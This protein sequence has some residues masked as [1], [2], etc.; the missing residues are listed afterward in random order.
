MSSLINRT[1]IGF[2]AG[3]LSVL[4]FH[5][6]MIGLLHATGLIGFAPF[7]LG[8][9]GPLRVPHLLDMC[10]WG[11]VWGIL[12]GILAPRLPGPAWLQGVLLGVAAVLAGHLLVTPLKGGSIYQGWGVHSLAI[13]LAI[14]CFWGIGVALLLPSLQPGR[15]LARP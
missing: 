15:R 5:Q 14:N 11:G 8:A 4:T 3:A 7:P 9:V 2:I 10:F 12:Y 1:M 13:G 6:A